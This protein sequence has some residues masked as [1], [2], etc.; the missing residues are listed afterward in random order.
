MWRHIYNCALW[1]SI[2]FYELQVSTKP[3]NHFKR[4]KWSSPLTWFPIT[5]ERVLDFHMIWSPWFL[6]LLL[7]LCRV[8][9]PIISAEIYCGSFARAVHGTRWRK[10][11]P[12]CLWR[13]WLRSPLPAN[14]SSQLSP[15]KC[16]ESSPI[17]W[18]KFDFIVL[19]LIWNFAYISC[20]L[21]QVRSGFQ[22]RYLTWFSTK[23]MADDASVA[24]DVIRFVCSGY[25]PPVRSAI[26]NVD[27][28]PRWCIL[29]W[30]IKSIRVK[31]S[32]LMSGNATND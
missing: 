32:Y 15:P 23:H 24:V 26:S 16:D 17:Y 25:T 13:N 18:P 29:G 4:T 12:Q 1:V 21:V 9:L 31:H 30:L 20:S 11:A 5:Y 10:A 8:A 7:C 6:L 2:H 3:S 27:V 14:I 28:V 19:K 22:H